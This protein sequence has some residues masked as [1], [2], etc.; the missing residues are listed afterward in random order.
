MFR[1]RRP[2]MSFES[3]DR[4]TTGIGWRL[5][6]LAALAAASSLALAQPCTGALPAPGT[7][8]APVPGQKFTLAATQCELLAAPA[9]VHRAAQLGLYDGKGPV[10]VAMP[11][12]EAPAAAAS[13]P[14]PAASVPLSGDAARI[15]SLA[16]TLTAA[17]QAYDLDP[18]LLHAI[19]HVES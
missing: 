3:D 16:P 10:A 11:A 12:P 13:A 19:A 6:A 2:A 7:M 18:L 8:P 14:A 1:R 4:D 5:A 17:A 15:V 9:Q